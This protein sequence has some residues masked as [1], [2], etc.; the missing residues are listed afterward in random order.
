[1]ICRMSLAVWEEI[2]LAGWKLVA[3]ILVVGIIAV[4]AVS[5]AVAVAVAVSVAVAVAVSV[6]V[7]SKQSAVG[8]RQ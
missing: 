1:M 5:V 8:S 2:S 3:V 4:V 7:N 6:A